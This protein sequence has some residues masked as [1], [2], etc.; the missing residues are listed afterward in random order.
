MENTYRGCRQS[1]GDEDM[2]EEIII[3]M[4]SDP[5][6]AYARS[7]PWDYDGD[8]FWYWDGNKYIWHE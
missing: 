8:G 3:R 6:Q 1:T 2:D 4:Q 5:L 7:I